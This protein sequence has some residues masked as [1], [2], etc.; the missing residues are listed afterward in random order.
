[1]CTG[2]K[3]LINFL[4]PAPQKK[5]LSTIS[6]HVTV[7]VI[8]GRSLHQPRRECERSIVT[9]HWSCDRSVL[10]PVLRIFWHQVCLRKICETSCYR[11]TWPFVTRGQPKMWDFFFS[12]CVRTQNKWYLGL[13][14]V[15]ETGLKFK[16]CDI[17]GKLEHDKFFDCCWCSYFKCCISK[18]SDQG[19]C[20]CFQG[21]RLSA[22][23][24]QEFGNMSIGPFSLQ[25]IATWKLAMFHTACTHYSKNSRC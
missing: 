12:F 23:A 11:V 1:M 4:S 20:T 13:S 2:Q 8:S 16:K 18:N 3:K 21:Q 6:R 9:V 17:H 24:G 5:W 22:Q 14:S 10:L 15:H 7:Y 25:K 19:T